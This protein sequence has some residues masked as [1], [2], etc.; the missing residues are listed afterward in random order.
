MIL[1]FWSFL[2]PFAVPLAL[3]MLVA[4][5]RRVPRHLL[6][7]VRHMPWDFCTHQPEQKLPSV[8]VPGIRSWLETWLPIALGLVVFTGAVWLLAWLG[9]L[10][11]GL[12]GNAAALSVSPP[13]L[14]PLSQFG[15]FC[16]MGLLTVAGFGLALLAVLSLSLAI[17]EGVLVGG[18]RAAT[19]TETDVASTREQP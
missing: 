9:W 7:P 6:P 16:L 10:A 4:A 1:T 15:W 3:I 18:R 14:E 5:A 17:G 11:T 13:S 8:A 12:H 19:Q 2:S